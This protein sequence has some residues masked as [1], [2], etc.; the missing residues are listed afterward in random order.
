MPPVLKIQ[1]Y[2][3]VCPFC[4]S[5]RFYVDPTLR[6]EFADE[7][8]RRHLLL[9]PSNQQYAFAGGLEESY[10]IGEVQPI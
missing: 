4:T 10:S 9:A 5:L 2:A 6:S 8:E 7:E 3:T 1:R